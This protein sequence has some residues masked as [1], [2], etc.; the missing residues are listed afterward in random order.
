MRSFIQKNVRL[1]YTAVGPLWGTVLGQDAKHPQLSEG[2]QPLSFNVSA[3]IH[4]Q[5]LLQN[6]GCPQVTTRILSEV[7]ET[8]HPAGSWE[9]IT[10]FSGQCCAGVDRKCSQRMSEVWLCGIASG[11]IHGLISI[12]SSS[13]LPSPRPWPV[14]MSMGSWDLFLL[15]AL[16][17]HR[18]PMAGPRFWQACRAGI[19]H[20]SV[21][22][23]TT[24]DPTLE[25]S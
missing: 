10:S 19:I 8:N 13:P 11:L 21:L 20:N 3:Q 5:H 22:G 16:P 12:F 4:P 25:S 2:N 14:Q 7:L 6:L 24:L 9:W 17:Q 1:G 18:R 15:A 23:L